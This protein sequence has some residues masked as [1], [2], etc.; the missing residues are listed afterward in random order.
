MKKLKYCTCGK[1]NQSKFSSLFLGIGIIVHV[2]LLIG[3]L[4]MQPG[5]FLLAVALVAADIWQ[6]SHYYRQARRLKHKEKCA[7]RYA[8][9][10]TLAQNKALSDS[11]SD[12]K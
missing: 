9:L 7:K 6:Y 1:D 8:F 3:L 10:A 5:F 4:S 11:Y 2:V 12:Y